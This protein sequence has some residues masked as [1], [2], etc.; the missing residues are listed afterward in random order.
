MDNIKLY[1]KRL[2]PDETVLLKDDQILYCDEEVM[3][4]K[5]EV[6]KPRKDFQRGLSCYFLQKG[7]KVS[8]FLNKNDQLVYHYCDIIDTEMDLV[9]STYLFHDLLVDVII[10]PTGKIRLMD[11]GEL[12]DALNQNIISKELAEKALWRLDSLLEIL[13]RQDAG[14]FMKPYLTKAGVSG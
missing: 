5:W 4:T 11:L 7:Y 14:E 12:A 10:E 3:V 13:Y 6:L 8:K 9:N 2:I 1:R